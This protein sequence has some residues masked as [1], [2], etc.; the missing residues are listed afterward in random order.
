MKTYNNLFEKICSFQ[1]LH[2]AYLKA[3]KCKRYKSEILKFSW[4]L[5]ENLLKLE[6]ELLNQNY[7]HGGYRE[8][9]VRDAKKRHIKAAPFRDR[10][11]HHALYRI[12]E[13]IFNKG[14]VYSSYACRENKGTHEAIKRLETYLTAFDRAGGGGRLKDKKNSNRV[15]CLK[16]DI[17]KYFASINHQILLKLNRKKI[18]DKKVLWLIEKILESTYEKKPGVGIPI[19]NLTSQLFANI[20]LDELDQF[21][22]HRLRVKYYIRYMDDFLILDYNK[23][24]LREIKKQVQEFLWEKLGLK[25][26]PKKANVFPASKGIDFLGYQILGTRRLLRKNTVKRFIK[27]TRMYQKMLNKGFLSKEKFNNSLQSWTAYAEFGNSWRLRKNLS[28]KLRVKLI[29]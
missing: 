16:C 10:V 20:Y 4:N 21:V 17:S 9:V 29:K 27:R 28:E 19:G 3:R 22:K 6:K 24:K 26:H 18:V 14:F 23:N 13:P 7:Q 1:N 12:I 15:Y 5:E 25:L 2:L 11:L 8:F